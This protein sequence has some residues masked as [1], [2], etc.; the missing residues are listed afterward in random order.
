MSHL[1]HILPKQNQAEHTHHRR[2]SARWTSHRN[3]SCEQQLE[4]LLVPLTGVNGCM[5]SGFRAL[6][7][8]SSDRNLYSLRHSEGDEMSWEWGGR[9]AALL[10][11]GAASPFFFPSAG[12]THSYTRFREL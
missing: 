6:R 3:E 1:L 7:C 4:M 11:R 2:Q 10:S 5:A 9:E 8:L 12:V